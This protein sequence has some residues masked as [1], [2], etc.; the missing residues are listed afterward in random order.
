MPALLGESW[1]WVLWPL[2]ARSGWVTS[3]I[4]LQGC[5]RNSERAASHFSSWTTGGP[6]STRTRLSWRRW[7]R[8]GRTHRCLR[9]TY[10]FRVHPCTSGSGSYNGVAEKKTD[11]EAEGEASPKHFRLRA[12]PELWQN[13]LEDWIAVST[14]DTR[15]FFLSAGSPAG[16]GLA[17]EPQPPTSLRLLAWRT[18]CIRRQSEEALVKEEDWPAFAKHCKRTLQAVGIVAQPWVSTD[19]NI[20]LTSSQL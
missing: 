2:A 9:T 15:G 11:N 17:G 20:N 4:Y 19:Y 18:G 13:T 6:G 10:W 3:G 8:S 16:G 7:G 14:A 12:V 5:W 1:R